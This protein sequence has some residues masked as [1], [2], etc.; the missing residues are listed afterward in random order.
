M[1]RNI[2]NLK[3]NALVE[4]TPLRSVG[5]HTDIRGVSLYLIRFEF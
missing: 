2:S 4:A 3:H 5:H 1:K